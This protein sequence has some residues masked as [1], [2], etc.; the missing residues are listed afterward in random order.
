MINGDEG[1]EQFICGIRDAV[2]YILYVFKNSIFAAPL[3]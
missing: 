3:W 1:T 2:V